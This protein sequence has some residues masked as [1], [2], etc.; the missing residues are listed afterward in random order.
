MAVLKLLGLVTA[1]LLCKEGRREMC[2]SLR[3]ATGGA[4]AAARAWHSE[5]QDY[6]AIVAHSLLT[7]TSGFA[8]ISFINLFFSG[9]YRKH[10]LQEMLAL[11]TLLLKTLAQEQC[12]LHLNYI[13]TFC[14]FVCA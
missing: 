3:V 4:H 11:E 7:G 9:A 1:V 6:V 14:V 10:W 13:R 5:G 8:E 12:V 2:S